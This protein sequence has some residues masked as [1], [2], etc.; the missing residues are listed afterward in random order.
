VLSVFQ[1]VPEPS[2][3]AM[4]TAQLVVAGIR[5]VRRLRN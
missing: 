4:L 5:G 3:S 2:V 1:V